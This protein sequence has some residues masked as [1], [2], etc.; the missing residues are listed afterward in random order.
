MKV[1]VAYG[2]FVGHSAGTSKC[3]PGT[4]RLTSSGKDAVFSITNRCRVHGV[5]LFNITDDEV[6]IELV[7]IGDASAD[8]PTMDAAP[9]IYA[10]VVPRDASFQKDWSYNTLGIAWSA[11]IKYD[12]YDSPT[13]IYDTFPKP[14]FLFENGVAVHNKTTNAG[15]G[16]L[17]V[18]WL[19]MYSE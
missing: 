2:D 6:E 11:S 7:D 5:F 17:A 9:K 18:H 12:L 16:N 19:I 15:S 4:I 3:A 13:G 8:Y 10:T 1:K 14:G